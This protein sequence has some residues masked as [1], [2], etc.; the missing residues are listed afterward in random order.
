MKKAVGIFLIVLGVTV[1]LF[2]GLYVC[3]YGGIIQIISAIQA[4]PLSAK[5]IAVGVIRI[6]LAGFAGWMSM[7]IFVVSGWKLF[8]DDF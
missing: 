8:I 4:A 5:G 3:L 1:G 6:V 2:L 7:L